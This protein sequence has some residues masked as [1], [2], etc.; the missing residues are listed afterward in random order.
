VFP[1]VV[2]GVLQRT[3][4]DDIIFSRCSFKSSDVVPTPSSAECGCGKRNA[5]CLIRRLLPR[6]RDLSRIFRTTTDIA[7]D[8]THIH[9]FGRSYVET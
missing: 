9:L 2:A 8:Y 4:E 6:I 5:S 3:M 7:R 1:M